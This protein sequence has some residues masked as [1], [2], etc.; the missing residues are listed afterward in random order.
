M[1]P[2][3]TATQMST[4]CTLHSSPATAACWHSRRALQGMPLARWRRSG[5]SPACVL[6]TVGPARQQHQPCGLCHLL[7]VANTSDSTTS[8]PTYQ[9]GGSGRMQLQ[10]TDEIHTG[11]CLH[12]DPTCSAAAMSLVRASRRL[13]TSSAAC[14][15]LPALGRHVLKQHTQWRCN[16]RSG[17]F[18]SCTA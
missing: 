6:A 4:Q 18:G 13:M 1:P 16:M 8:Q 9:H 2:C 7:C 3:Y 5:R 10:L 11:H 15:R 14:D 12:T 17:I